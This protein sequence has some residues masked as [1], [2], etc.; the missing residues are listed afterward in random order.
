MTKLSHIKLKYNQLVIREKILLLSFLGLLLLVVGEFAFTHLYGQLIKVQQEN[1]ALA[2]QVAA[3]EKMIQIYQDYSGDNQVEKNQA[4]K[5]AQAALKNQLQQMK[6]NTNHVLPSHALPSLLENMLKSSSG[7]RLIQLK[8][9]PTKAL[10]TK[11][12]I[13]NETE[14]SSSQSP[15]MAH[16]PIKKNGYHIE[17]EG[18]FFSIL[19]FTKKIEQIETKLFWKKFTYKVIK[20]PA[21]RVHIENYS[22]NVDLPGVDFEK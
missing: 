20:H 4:L 15:S 7:L 21:A 10:E 18:D 11:T 9:M 19:D 3:E 5:K 6:N 22:L 17:L 2:L 16:Q 14:N 13:K 12:G 1:Q 8:P